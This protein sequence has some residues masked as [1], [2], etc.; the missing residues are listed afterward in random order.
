MRYLTAFIISF[1]IYLS[2]Y[3][4]V[5]LD[6]PEGSDKFQAHDT[7]TIRWSQVQAHVTLNWELYFSADGG[8]TWIEISK[9]IAVADREYKWIVPAIET[10]KGRIRVIQNNEVQDY[11]DVSANFSI[12]IP[13]SVKELKDDLKSFD[14]FPNPSHGNSHCTIHLLNKSEV[15]LILT[16]LTGNKIKTIASEVLDA[17]THK[18]SYALSNLPDGTYIYRLS[19]NGNITTRKLIILK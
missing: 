16:D 11:E 8:D 5:D 14:I 10:T 17:G 13:Q 15:E 18:F 3:S 1:L 4:H 19:V 12:E 9:T 6:Y 2:A 7:V